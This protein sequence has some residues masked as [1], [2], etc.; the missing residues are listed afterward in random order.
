MTAA[1]TRKVAHPV[2]V[3]KGKPKVK[4]VPAPTPPE[5]TLDDLL[6]KMETEFVQCRD[7][8][9][10]WRPHVARWVGKDNCYEV[11]RRCARCDTERAMLLSSRGQILSSAY[12]YPQGYQMKGMGRMTSSDRDHVR[13]ASLR[14]V[15]VKDT[16]Q[17]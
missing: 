5:P 4:A 8:G 9:H 7:F 17:E 13:L 3:T 6:G 10:S 11:I 16:V 14:T 2:T 1:R 15:L 12:D